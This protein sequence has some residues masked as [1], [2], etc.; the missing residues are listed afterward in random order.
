MSG[1]PNGGVLFRR[2]RVLF[3]LGERSALVCDDRPDQG[4]VVLKSLFR[5]FTVKAEYFTK[6]RF[7]CVKC[8][9]QSHLD[10]PYRDTTSERS[11][12][13]DQGDHAN[14]CEHQGATH[15]GFFVLGLISD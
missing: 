10:V 7:C 12:S 14:A 4:E 11:T 6:S 1:R 13:R 5:Q 9:R 3:L 2:G 8:R 15:L